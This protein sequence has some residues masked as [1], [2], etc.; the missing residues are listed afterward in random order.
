ML[1][2]I[3]RGADGH[4]DVPFPMQEDLPDLS[5]PE[6][7][8]SGSASVLSFHL[9]AYSKNLLV[10]GPFVAT[11]WAKPKCSIWRASCFPIMAFRFS[12]IFKTFWNSQ[13]ASKVAPSLELR[14]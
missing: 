5:E 1:P 12:S 11:W 10:W 4:G 9:V 2:I 6:G 7:E 3:A 13:F 8:S 14:E